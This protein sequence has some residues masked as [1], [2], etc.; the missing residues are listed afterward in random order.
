MSSNRMAPAMIAISATLKIPVRTRVDA[1]VHEVDDA[2]AAECT[3]DQIAGAAG[4]DERERDEQLVG[5]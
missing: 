4:N 3:I 1:D 5:S 2:A